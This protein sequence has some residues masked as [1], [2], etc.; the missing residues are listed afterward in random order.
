VIGVFFQSFLGGFSGAVVPGTL[1][2][3]TVQQALLIGWTAGLWLILGH[4][5]AELTLLVLLRAGLGGFLQRPK[6]TRV[7]GLVGGTVLLYFA[8]QMI[9]VIFENQLTNAPAGGTVVP[10]SGVML[11]GQGL[12]LTLVN[13]YWY[14]WWATVGVGLIGTLAGEHGH[15]AWPVFFV[16]HELADYLWYAVVSI[17]VAVSGR[18]L[19]PAIHHGIIFT[20]GVGI[21]VLG[22]YLIYRQLVGW[23]RERENSFIGH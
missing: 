18:F 20:S 3:I 16:G 4:M 15:R 17:F 23:A 13:P 8:W 11:A 6:T 10:L 1:F 21:A 2:A 7:I 12:L 9:A 14:L 22:I 19:S 5:M